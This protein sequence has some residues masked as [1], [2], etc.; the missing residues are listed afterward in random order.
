MEC[1]ICKNSFTIELS[2]CP[3]CGAMQQ[4]SV[5]EELVTISSPK[6]YGYCEKSDEIPAIPKPVELE[7]IFV[8]SEP[9]ILGKPFIP[10]SISKTE[11]SEAMPNKPQTAAKPKKPQVTEPQRVQSKTENLV[12]FQQKNN[13]IPEWRLQLKNA[14]RERMNERKV[15]QETVSTA[16]FSNRVLRTHGNAALKIAPVYEEELEIEET[17]TGAIEHENEKVR[18]ALKRIELSRMQYSTKKDEPKIPAE[19]EIAES[20]EKKEYPFQLASSKNSGELRPAKKNSIAAPPRP[21][22][23]SSLRKGK[24]DFDTNKLPPLPQT[25]RIV[26]SFQTRP[27]E[28]VAVIEEKVKVK[29]KETE[30]ISTENTEE[31]IIVETITT[32]TAEEKIIVENKTLSET[33][34]KQLVDIEAQEEYEANQEAEDFAPFTL[35]FNAG[36]FDLLI[37]AFASLILLSPFMMLGG[38][39]FTFGGFFAYLFTMA[40]VM[41]IYLTATVGMFGKSFGMRL[42][43]L[44]IIDIENEDYPTFHQAAV[45][46]AVYLASVAL[47]GLGFLTV[48]FNEEQRAVHD[49]VSNTLVVKEL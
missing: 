37:G 25:A 11:Q 29:I 34:I 20:Q 43:S 23:V 6:I 38:D 7:M 16:S 36:I 2:I 35:R 47:G 28:T 10:E 17:P 21:T 18:N 4:D 27:V 33:E 39:W 12:E 45:S 5:R 48:P 44:E 46:S 31:N 8:S 32:E 41:F 22:L 1:V 49:L 13:V 26:S 24:D 14:V 15:E 42:F 40:I 3:S 30:T 19:E 9:E